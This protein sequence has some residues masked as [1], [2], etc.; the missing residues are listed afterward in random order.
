M[1]D[2]QRIL[3]PTDFSDAARTACDYACA[4]AETFGAQLDILHVFDLPVAAMP[5][6]GAVF[7]PDYFAEERRRVAE[8]LAKVPDT[9]PPGVAVQHVTREGTAF[10]EIVRYARESAADL[11]V[12]G[13]HGRTGLAHLL[14]GS[15]A[16][17]VVRKAPCPVLTVRPRDHRFV[18]P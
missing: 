14:I 10:L 3:H 18:M 8:E 12:M 15:V 17:R 13:S 1:I 11:I 4:L 7:P 16:E 9:A 2:L 5:S 6:P